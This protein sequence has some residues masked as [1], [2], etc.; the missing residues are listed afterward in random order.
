VS[1]SNSIFAQGKNL[2]AMHGVKSSPVL[3]QCFISQ[4]PTETTL[5]IPRHCYYKI[6]TRLFTTMATSTDQPISTITSTTDEI[7]LTDFSRRR[8]GVDN[9]STTA[10]PSPEESSQESLLSEI[11]DTPKVSWLSLLAFT[12]RQHLIVLYSALFLSTTSGFVLPC[13][14]ILLGSIFGAF[15]G[16]GSG[17]LQP[18]E[19]M[20]KVT[21]HITYLTLLGC[22]SWLLN[23]AFFAS[24]IWFGELQAKAAREKLFDSLIDN[25]IGWF[26]ERKDGVSAMLSKIQTYVRSLQIFEGPQLNSFADKSRRYKPRFPSH[27]LT[28]RNQLLLQ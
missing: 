8:V 15:A 16:F 5:H 11:E 18:E 26:E 23:G 27:L 19:F 28:P 17:A 1:E 20:A 7:T 6:R 2:V 12:N 22:A 14:S 9:A 24:W 25:E 13:M 4:R 10:V 21:K 3:F